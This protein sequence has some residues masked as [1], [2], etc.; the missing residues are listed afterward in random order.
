MK[1]SCANEVLLGWGLRAVTR[2]AL[3]SKLEPFNA[4]RAEWTRALSA[5]RDDKAPVFQ[6]AMELLCSKDVARSRSGVDN[7]STGDWRRLVGTVSLVIN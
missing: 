3:L 2:E 5:W 7:R 4:I 6:G 1:E